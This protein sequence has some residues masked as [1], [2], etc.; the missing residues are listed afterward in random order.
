MPDHHRI[1]KDEKTILIRGDD[2]GA[3]TAA[4]S[5]EAGTTPLNEAG[6]GAVETFALADGQGVLRPCRR[7]GFVGKFMREGYLFRNRPKAEFLIHEHLYESGVSVPEPLGVM[8]Q[9]RSL[10]VRGSLATRRLEAVGLNAWLVDA[11]RDRSKTLAAAG[12]LIRS[13]HD[14]GVYHADLHVE[15]ILVSGGGEVFLIDFDN[16]ALLPEVSAT[17]RARNLLRLRRS[18]LKRGLDEMDYES[19]LAAYGPI[20][21]PSWLDA[22]YRLKGKVSDLLAAS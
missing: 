9:R 1:E 6:R 7:G 14:A 18:F 8:W 15:N 10:I 5:G 11:P 13:M 17:Q 16:A 3:I 20:A 19:I 22:A 2:A 12:Q 21:I 4:L